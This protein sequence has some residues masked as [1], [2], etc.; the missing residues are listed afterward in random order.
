MGM[1]AGVCIAGEITCG[2]YL[3]VAAPVILFQPLRARAF[4]LS[5]LVATTSQFTICFAPAGGHRINYIGLADGQ[6]A[7]DDDPENK[8]HSTH[9][10][11]PERPVPSP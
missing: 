10:T 5:R 7:A 2:R 8:S 4:T 3:S 11:L 9:T 1:G 6:Q